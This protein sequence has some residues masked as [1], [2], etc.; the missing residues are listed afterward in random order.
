MGV[1]KGTTAVRAGPIARKA[2]AVTLG[3]EVELEL[4]E[5]RMGTV[6]I[7]GYPLLMLPLVLMVL[8]LV[9][10][11]VGPPELIGITTFGVSDAASLVSTRQLSAGDPGEIRP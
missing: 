3:L 11:R 10:A 1:E 9:I 8:S 4:M 6:S 2:R 7:R 5:G